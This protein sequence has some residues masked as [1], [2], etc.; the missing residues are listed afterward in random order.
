V[1]RLLQAAHNNIESPGNSCRFGSAMFNGQNQVSATTAQVNLAPLADN[2][3]PT[4]TRLPGA[5]SI[6]INQGRET[7]CTPTDQRHYARADTQ[8]DV[9]AVEVG[10]TPDAL[11]ASGFD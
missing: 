5:G 2:G 7:N 3:G 6:A 10:A 9:G 11:F 1:N 8:C 4:W